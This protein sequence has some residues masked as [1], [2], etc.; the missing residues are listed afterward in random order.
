MIKLRGRGAEGK[1][2]PLDGFALLEACKVEDPEEAVEVVLH[3]HRFGGVV[4]EDLAFFSNLEFFDAGENQIALQD[5]LPLKRLEEVHLHCN[6]LRQVDLSEGFPHLSTLNLSFNNFADAS[7][8]ES[9]AVLPSLHRLDMTGNRLTCL[10][11]GEVMKQFSQL[12]QLALENNNLEGDG[13]FR[14]LSCVPG[15][16]EVNLNGNRL[17]NVPVLETELP[18]EGEEGGGAAVP[19]FLSLQVIG[20]ANNR[21]N[22]FEDLFALS[23]IVHLRRAVLW[24]NPIQHRRGDVEILVHEL[25][26]ANIVA[27]LE[28]P[29][30]PKKG[31]SDFYGANAKNMVKVGQFKRQ[32]LRKPRNCRK[33]L[34]KE[35]EGEEERAEDVVHKPEE[36]EEDY[37]PTFFMTELTEK[38]TDR[39]ASSR[40]Q[41][42]SAHKSIS[43]APPAA[44]VVGG[45]GDADDAWFQV[46]HATE[47]PRVNQALESFDEL[48]NVCPFNLAQCVVIVSKFQKQG[49]LFP[50]NILFAY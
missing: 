36:E 2:V 48:L 13:I 43:P 20:L 35:N 45:L 9:L 1:R 46:G 3:S 22:F 14:S 40:R 30:P 4:S 37:D 25:S 28:G 26:T 5:L 27:F 34:E 15:L 17:T 10:P 29:L 49:K 31:L 12:V 8:L 11:S 47:Q 6:Q 18:Q 32:P 33:S 7:V 16:Q 24:G 21:F 39:D 41:S 23:K 50:S 19:A 42:L 38:S 44:S